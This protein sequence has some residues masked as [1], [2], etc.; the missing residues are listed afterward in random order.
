[1]LV[2][3][4]SYGEGGG[5][6]LRTSLVL[7][8]VTG[9]PFVLKNIRAGRKKPGLRPQHIA[10]VKAI[11]AL[12]KAEVKGLEPGSKEIQFFPRGFTDVH[13]QKFYIPTAGSATLLF[14]T[15]FYPAAFTNGLKAS[16]VGG[17]HVPFSPTYEYLEM[18]FLPLVKPLGLNAKL[19]LKKPGFVPKGKGEF[20]AEIFPLF[21]DVLSQK[22]LEIFPDF[23]EISV[24]AFFTFTSGK[25]A[26]A[27]ELKKKIQSWPV[28]K[29][30]NFSV[31]ERTFNTSSEGLGLTFVIETKNGINAGFSLVTPFKEKDVK[32][33]K[34][35][36]E[37]FLTLKSGVDEF[38]GDQL[39]LPISLLVYKGLLKKA[40]YK[41][42]RVTRHLTTQAWL[43]PQF[44]PSLKVIVSN[45]E[46]LVEATS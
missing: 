39:L 27:L 35:K 11:K 41:V 5:Q 2:L 14:Q 26:F 3:D 44:I 29:K 32:S 17:T 34:E 46:V 19:K 16:F 43:I 30:L 18:V 4:G 8:A 40:V 24:K 10:C 25:R 9:K 33:L 7:S 45:E 13:Q 6:I 1:V 38:A 20:S 23:S 21:K 37:E 42:V 15:V 28:F 36:L 12:T 31:F 22:N